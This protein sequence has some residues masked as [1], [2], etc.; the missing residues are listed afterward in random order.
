MTYETLSSDHQN[1]SSR[2]RLSLLVLRA[3]PHS[4][5]IEMLSIIGAVSHRLRLGY[6]HWISF[7]FKSI[8]ELNAI[9]RKDSACILHLRLIF[10]VISRILKKDKKENIKIKIDPG[11]WTDII[12]VF[13]KY[14]K[15]SWTFPSEFGS[16][17]VE[18]CIFSF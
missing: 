12:S 4:Q 13:S 16:C 10:W 2:F 1:L 17:F 9:I 3:A 18:N 7:S 6:L 15:S 11:Y 8:I 5:H 14:R